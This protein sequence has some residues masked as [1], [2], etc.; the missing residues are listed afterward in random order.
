[1]ARKKT[2][3][4]VLA[5]IDGVEV[6]LHPGH[7]RGEMP[8]GPG[9]PRGPHGRVDVVDDPIEDSGTRVPEVREVAG[10]RA[11]I[12]VD[13]QHK[14][15]GYQHGPTDPGILFDYRVFNGAIVRLQPPEWMDDRGVETIRAE[16]E[17]YGAKVVRVGPRRKSRVLT[18]A[19]APTQHASARAVVMQLVEE[20]NVDDRD[21]LR[22]FCDAVMQRQGVS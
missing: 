7:A 8:W 3:R 1:M 21:A 2:N 16:I 13:Q 18:E 11:V 20:S 14:A 9:G 5:A 10:A 22:T 6:P 4:E 12:T 17:K 15:W 19:R